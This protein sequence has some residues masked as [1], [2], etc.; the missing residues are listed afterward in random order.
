M[1]SSAY[2]R[3]V[4]VFNWATHTNRRKHLHSSKCQA[5]LQVFLKSP[6]QPCDVGTI[7]IPLFQMRKLRHR[8]AKVTCLR[9]QSYQVAKLG[10]EPKPSGFR[11]LAL[12]HSVDASSGQTGPRLFTG[13]PVWGHKEG[14][15]SEERS[16]VSIPE[17]Q[18]EAPPEQRPW[19][20][21]KEQ[22]HWSVTVTLEALAWL[23]LNMSH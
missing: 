23:H 17:L 4:S 9:S 1:D 11:V 19:R 6:Q 15:A 10:F 22:C 2:P 12:K 3:A 16:R 7:I 20:T 8:E 14:P 21:T 18:G 13:C 5:L